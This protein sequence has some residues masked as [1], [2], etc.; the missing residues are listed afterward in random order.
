MITIFS[1]LILSIFLFFLGFICLIVKRNLLYILIGLEIMI[2]SLALM[3]VFIG[4]YWKQVDGQIMYIFI[5]TIAA[6]EASIGLAFLIN[7]YKYKN[8]LDIN[9][10]SEMKK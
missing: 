4:N 3:M 1:G 2:N 9:V 7:I 5:I 8:T 10:L 6:S